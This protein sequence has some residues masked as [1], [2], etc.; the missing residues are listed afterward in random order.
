MPSSLSASAVSIV[1]PTLGLASWWWD[2]GMC[3]ILPSDYT[4]QC[5]WGFPRVRRWRVS[6]GG[7]S[8]RR[9]IA[10]AFSQ[11]LQDLERET[12]GWPGQHPSCTMVCSPF[13]VPYRLPVLLRSNRPTHSPKAKLGECCSVCPP[14]CGRVRSVLVLPS[15]CGSDSISKTPISDEDTL[16]PPNLQQ[17]VFPPQRKAFS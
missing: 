2:G 15:S 1:V 9:I 3:D 6:Q 5:S 7:A 4:L 8:T 17:C 10:K 12:P 13:A 16:S 14:A 11:S